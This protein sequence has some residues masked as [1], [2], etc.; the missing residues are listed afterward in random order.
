MAAERAIV[1][2][3]QQ[4]AAREVREAAAAVEAARVLAEHPA[5]PLPQALVQTDALA[6]LADR[7]RSFG[8]QSCSA[9]AA[10]AHHVTVQDIGERLSIGL[11][12]EVDGR[13]S[14]FAVLG[15]ASKFEVAIRAELGADTEVETHI[16]PLEV[17]HLVGED[18]PPAVA[19]EISATITSLAAT[20]GTIRNV[21]D[22]RVRQTPAGLVV[23]YHCHADPALD[24]QASM[25]RSIFLNARC[26]AHT[27]TSS[28]SLP[29]RA[30]L[31]QTSFWKTRDY[32]SFLIVYHNSKRG[33]AAFIR[34]SRRASRHPCRTTVP[35]ASGP[36]QW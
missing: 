30:R 2:G 12:I 9:R 23:N 34:R 11:D 35:R 32:P 13:M 24:I 29:C 17:P 10:T 14:L 27:R 6:Q 8:S 28:V 4:S 33:L 36:R 18:A 3:S 15:L 19:S 16:E 21:H 5:Q 26:A 1:R 31:I 20:I 25:T 22:V 7:S